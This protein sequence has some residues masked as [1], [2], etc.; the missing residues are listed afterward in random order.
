MFAVSVTGSLGSRHSRASVHF[1]GQASIGVGNGVHPLPHPARRVDHQEELVWLP[2]SAGVLAGWRSIAIDRKSGELPSI[3][4]SSRA[5]TACGKAGGFDFPRS[6]QVAPGTRGQYPHRR[7]DPCRAYGRASAADCAQ[8]R[9][10]VARA[11]RS[12]EISRHGDDAHRPPSSPRGRDLPTSRPIS[13]TGSRA[14]WRAWPRRAKVDTG[15]SAVRDFEVKPAK[16]SRST[17]CGWD[18]N[19]CAVVDAAAWV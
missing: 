8:R 14:K 2:S 12:K 1:H 5:A 18:Y 15:M 10:A 7:R 19:W 9:R 16:T 13:K 3:R 6:T 4:S 17:A 11:I